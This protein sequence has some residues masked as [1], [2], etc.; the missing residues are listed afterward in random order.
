VAV[1]YLKKGSPV[2]ITGS[3]AME[4]YE[5]KDGGGQGVKLAVDA[6]DLVLL[7]AKTQ[8]ADTSAE[9]VAD[10][11]PVAKAMQQAQATTATAA[12]AAVRG[13]EAPF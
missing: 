2:M 3:L 13:D 9:T 1:N 12:P 11:A 5:K 10:I 8:G 7:G 4:T 6:R